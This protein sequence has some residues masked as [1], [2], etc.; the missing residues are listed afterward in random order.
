VIPAPVL[1]TGLLA[2]PLDA[3]NPPPETF[4]TLHPAAHRWGR[5]M[6]PFGAVRR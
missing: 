2:A 3:G 4:G 1:T 6:L 5:P